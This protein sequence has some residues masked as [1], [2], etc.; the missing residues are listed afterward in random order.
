[1]M[2]RNTSPTAIGRTS[3]FFLD[4][5]VS[6]AQQSALE[7]KAGKS[8]LLPKFTNFVIS[9]RANSD[10]SGALL[11]MFWKHLRGTGCSVLTEC[12]Q[13]FINYVFTKLERIGCSIVRGKL[14]TGNGSFG[15][16]LSSALNVALL[17]GA[18]PSEAITLAAWP[19]WP[20]RHNVFAWTNISSM[21]LVLC[22]FDCFKQTASDQSFPYSPGFQRSKRS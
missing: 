19:N 7:I 4:K 3:P 9:F 2:R 10:R 20:C 8:P 12:L 1:M 18:K 11:K 13:L 21:L 15:C 5:A 6:E 14:T 22:L 16:N 17:S